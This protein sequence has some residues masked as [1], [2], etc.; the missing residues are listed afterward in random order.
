M[1]PLLHDRSSAFNFTHMLH[2]FLSA[3][4]FPGPTR[5]INLTLHQ[6]FCWMLQGH[7]DVK[8]KANPCMGCMASGNYLVRV[9]LIT[10]QHLRLVLW[11]EPKPS[12]LMGSSATPPSWRS[13]GSLA[14]N[15]VGVPQV[16]VTDHEAF[17]VASGG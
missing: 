12:W 6:E 11:A 1:G 9:Q 8:R 10:S 16:L 7:F 17:A 3:L 4:I 13:N 2:I 14:S 5:L 15:P